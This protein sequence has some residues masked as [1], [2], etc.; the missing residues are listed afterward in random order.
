MKAFSIAACAALVLSASAAQAATTPV[1]LASLMQDWAHANY[2]MADP[3][4]KSA[5]MKRLAA[6]A[7]TAATEHAGQAE[8]L[9]WDAII[10]GSEAGLK[11]GLGALGLAKRARDL[12]LKAEAINP[13]VL[14]GS[15]YTTLGSLYDQVPGFPIGFGDK[16]KAGAF[17]SRALALNPKGIDS[18]YFYGLHLEGVGDY[19]GA[20]RALDTALRAAPRPGRESADKGRRQEISA[21]L[22]RVRAKVKA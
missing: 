6:L 7:D 18:N 12:A 20:E 21:A 22:T 11:G 3:A 15:V 14:D 19:A 1:T 4:A 16:K 13:K 17:L 5:E 2:E 8:F 10:T 9:V